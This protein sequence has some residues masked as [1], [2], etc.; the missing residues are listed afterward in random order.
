MSNNCAGEVQDES[1]QLSSSPQG[2]SEQQPLHDQSWP[3]QHAQT[4]DSE[5]PRAPDDHPLASRGATQQPPYTQEAARH[6]AGGVSYNCPQSMGSSFAAPPPQGGSYLPYPSHRTRDEPSRHASYDYAYSADAAQPQ[7]QA[8]GQASAQLDSGEPSR[9]GRYDSQGQRQDQPYN[10][11]DSYSRPPAG[12]PSQDQP[13][14]S[15]DVFSDHPGADRWVRPGDAFAREADQQQPNLGSGSDAPLN[16]RGSEYV[17]DL[18]NSHGSGYDTHLDAGGSGYDTHLNTGASGYDTHLNTGGSDYDTHPN[19]G[20]SDYDTH[21]DTGGS[22]YDTQPDTGAPVYGHSYTGGANN[23]NAP[24]GWTEGIPAA[25]DRQAAPIHHEPHP[26]SHPMPAGFTGSYSIRRRTEH[27]SDSGTWFQPPSWRPVPPDEV[28][29]EQAQPQYSQYDQ[30][31][32]QDRQAEPQYGQYEH[33]PSQHQQPEPRHHDFQYASANYQQQEPSFNQNQQ[34]VQQRDGFEHA[35]SHYQQPEPGYQSE[36]RF[37]DQQEPQYSQHQHAPPQQQQ[38][39]QQQQQLQEQEQQQ[40]QLQPS[41]AEYQHRQPQVQPAEPVYSQYQREQW[42]YQLPSPQHPQDQWQAHLSGQQEANPQHG[43][44]EYEMP[45]RQDAVQ[46]QSQYDEASY[47]YAQPQHEHDGQALPQQE[48]PQY[49]QRE[50]E[51]YQQQQQQ[52][53]SQQYRQYQHAPSDLHQAQPQHGHYNE[54]VAQHQLDTPSHL[55]QYDSN[56]SQGGALQREEDEQ[57]QHAR[58]EPQQTAAMETQEGEAVAWHQAEVPHPAQSEPPSQ[59]EQLMPQHEREARYESP[60]A[61][62]QQVY[63]QPAFEHSWPEPEH[64]NTQA[65][66]PQQSDQT[67]RLQADAG[68]G[69]GAGAGAE[70]GAV[71]QQQ[72]DPQSGKPEEP[73]LPRQ[74]YDH[75]QYEESALQ[76]QQAEPQH[77]QHQETAALQPWHEDLPAGRSAL[78][79]KAES[80]LSQQPGQVPS[81][82]AT[83]EGGLQGGAREHAVS[84]AEQYI[85]TAP[86]PD[87]FEAQ[88]AQRAHAEHGDLQPASQQQRQQQQQAASYYRRGLSSQAQISAQGGEAAPQPSSGDG[89]SAGSSFGELTVF[90]CICFCLLLVQLCMTPACAFSCTDLISSQT[91]PDLISAEKNR[92][93]LWLRLMSPIST[94]ASLL[95]PWICK[96]PM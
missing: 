35:P 31:P 78:P 6:Q 17:A 11:E 86:Q 77:E 18:L 4:V 49:E 76:R 29:Y 3:S 62:P 56:L 90:F 47:H 22:G 27:S 20:G 24:D 26:V 91:W 94:Q 81:Q 41:Y 48:F 34:A 13:H 83:H 89:L 58:P 7:L 60:R 39:Q 14:D 5:H 38:Q 16:R 10:M 55:G 95:A 54:A 9:V 67:E 15:V 25:G 59:H 28:L 73:L 96:P 12:Q 1:P 45:R 69:A 61:E 74:Q 64:G 36:Y 50:Q 66:L 32:L 37:Q 63:R 53:M 21:P 71:E 93:H 87:Q 19:T 2:L 84:Q 33:R 65:G 92:P 30:A 79:H 42:Q 23:R 88:E 52:Q 72:A 82:S 51:P 80:E 8:R 40:E 57:Y 46:Q 68:A 70:A 43:Q 44:Y 75:D 85:P